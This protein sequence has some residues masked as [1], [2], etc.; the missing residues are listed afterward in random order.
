MPALQSGD[1][2][3]FL[4]IIAALAVIAMGG[5]A[6]ADTTLYKA[7][8]PDSSLKRGPS[9]SDLTDQ[10]GIPIVCQGV[11]LSDLGGNRQMVQFI[12]PDQSVLGFG[13]D[14]LDF[15]SDPKFITLPLKRLYLPSRIKTGAPETVDG[16]EGFCFLDGRKVEALK[17]VICVAQVVLGNEHVV[18]QVEAKMQGPAQVLGKGGGPAA[19]PP[20]PPA[21]KAP[22]A[23]SH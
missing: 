1:E 6:A 4:G 14:E 17:G 13:G 11:M 7:A 22:A 3:R 18:Y 15:K 16:V 10:A 20:S 9:G 23:K 21:V 19:Q 2:M 8:C 12:T 5:P